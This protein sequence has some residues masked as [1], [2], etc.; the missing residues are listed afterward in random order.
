MPTATPSKLSLWLGLITATL[1]ALALGAFWCL[2][3][4]R[5]GYELPWFALIC[6]YVVARVLRAH[7]Y[8]G[9]KRGIAIAA[10]CTALAC[11][12]S[13]C[14]L[15]VADVAQAMG[16]SLRAALPQIGFDFTFAAARARLDAIAVLCFA[17]AIVLAA[18]L[19]GMRRRQ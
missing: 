13:Q 11:G 16:I 8:A 15:A 6:G 14:L 3:E 17:A 18:V 12:Y 19:T 10:L 7:G 1:L 5:C 4:L 2:L 9:T